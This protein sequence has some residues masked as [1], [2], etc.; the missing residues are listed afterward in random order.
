MS[1]L[2]H[3]GRGGEERV[4]ARRGRVGHQRHVGF[5]DRLPAGDRR[6]VE[7][8]AVGE[9]VLVDQRLIEG[10]VLPLAAR[11]GEAQVDI[12]DVVV[13][14]RLQDIL[15][16]LHGLPFL[17]IELCLLPP[18]RERRA[19]PLDQPRN[20]VRPRPRRFRRCGCGSPRRSAIRISCHR[21]CG[22]S[23]RRCG[24]PRPPGEILVGDDDLDLH[25]GQKVD[26]IFG[27]AIKL[28]VALLAAEALRLEDGDALDARLLQRLLHLV[29]LERLDDRLDLLHFGET[30]RPRGCRRSPTGRYRYRRRS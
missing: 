21:R 4:H 9:R 28:G 25:L 5:V 8:Q 24:S 18:P 29:E 30:P 2:M 15:G 19:A 27:A 3:H 10:D 26:D 22:R 16:G 12:F 17:K 20:A 23:A 11:I 7:H 13:L 1:Q 14:D 6:A